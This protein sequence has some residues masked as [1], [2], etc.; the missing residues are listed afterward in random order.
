MEK[1]IDRRNFV[2]GAAVGAAGLVA[3]GA[4]AANASGTALATEPDSNDDSDDNSSDEPVNTADQKWDFE[5][6][7]E[8]ISD[9]D[10]TDTIEADVVVVGGGMSGLI[11]A[12]S[13]AENGL[14]VILISAS[15]AP[16]SRGGSNNG[17]YSTVMEEMDLPKMDPTWFYRVQYEA[18]GGNFK[19]ALWYKFYNNSEEAMNWLV[20]IAAKADIKTTIESGPVYEDGDPM[21][22]PPAAHAF[23]VDDDELEG[24]VGN[25]EYHIAEELGRYIEEDLGVDVHWK[26]KAEQLV[27]GDK[28]NGTSGRVDAVIASDEDGNY[29]KFKGSKAI[30]MATGDFSHNKSMMERYCPQAIELCDFTTEVNYDQGL[31]MGGLYDGEGQQMELWVGGAWQKEQ[32]N[33]MLG[34][35]NLPGDQP[36]TS[37]TGLMVNKDGQRFMNENVLGGLACATI[38]HNPDN[39]AYCI[40]GQNRAEAGAPWAAANYPQGETF[41]AEEMIDRWDNDTDGF[42]IIKADTREEIIEQLGLPEETMDTI[43]RYNEKC[44]N[45]EDTDFYKTADKLISIGEDDGPFYGA[46]F[47]PGFLTTLGGIRTD[48]HLRALD[49]KDEVIEGLFNAGTMIGGFYSGTYT[50]AMEGVNYGATCVTLPYVLGK[51]LTDGTLD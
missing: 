9:D 46:V 49:E 51:E 38:M 3:A 11:S 17:V 34:R 16:V 32:N 39:A 40:W 14:N 50:F 4:L 33:I 41:T 35:P 26:T 24:A 20:D 31:W 47:T 7:P 37:H 10:I 45:G 21:F 13:C 48:T 25:G 6:A 27:R 8:A 28:P 23:Y 15:E 18:N 12:T 19:P 42:G 43:D 2:K 1:G 5:I 30:I 29:I 22:T 36:Y 44:E